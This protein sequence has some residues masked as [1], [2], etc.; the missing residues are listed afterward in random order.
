LQAALL[1]TQR[2]GETLALKL[3]D[4][5]NRGRYRLLSEKAPDK[6]ELAAKLQVSKRK[7]IK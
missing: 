1:L 4:P 5:S 6:E 7:S 2:E 3:E